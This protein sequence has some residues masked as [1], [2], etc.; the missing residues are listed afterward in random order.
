MTIHDFISKLNSLIPFRQAEDFDNVGLLCGVPEREITRVLIAHDALEE[1]ID[2]A[3]ARGANVVLAFHPIIFSGLKSI[4]GKNYVER[5]V[6]KAIEK[7]IAI[8]AIHT[9]LDNDFLGVNHQIG[10][11][12][13]LENLR[14]LMPKNKS[15]KQL[16]VYVP[17]DHLEVLKEALFQA[18]AGNIGFYD[19][20]SYALGG[21]GTFRPK[22]G[23]NPYCGTIGER[24]T[25]E[26]SA[27]SVIFED[28]KLPAV[29]E[30]MKSAH[31]YE[32]VAYHIYTLDNENQYLGLGQ[33]GELPEE[34]D[35]WD[36]LSLIKN[37]FNLKVV[38]YSPLTN[39]K[40]KKVGMIGGSGTI[41]IK[42]A[43]AKG[44]DAYLTGDVK[45]H[46]FYQGEDKML[47]CDIGHFESEQF[48]MTQ[49]F[50]I[51]SE[52]FTTFA[53]LKTT[54]NTNPVNYFI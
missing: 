26:E 12:L 4:T 23:A 46:E 11:E 14:T 25:T 53:V 10:K 31:P 45:Y 2:E 54:Q 1:V 28:Y 15:L 22:K 5:A 32:E 13:G 27:L 44:C 47:I 29:I 18:G 42:A 40:I 34:M 50:E 16:V 7:K 51:L 20:C 24:E 52:N 17:N 36:F 3:E 38:R 39:K 8:I 35:E 41:G 48:V 9:A 30:A 49:L 43:L 21:N 37:K 6:L 33:Y 19:E